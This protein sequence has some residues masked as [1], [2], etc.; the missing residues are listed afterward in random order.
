MFI[1][2]IK[3]LP[4]WLWEARIFWLALSVVIIALVFTLYFCTSESAIRWTGLVLQLLGVGTV[5]WGLR[6][7]R[8]LFGHLSLA[9]KA[10]SWLSRFPLHKRNVIHSSSVIF[11]GG[12]VVSIKGHATHKPS[13]DATM[14]QRLDAL[15]RNID[16]LHDRISGNEDLSNQKFDKTAKSLEKERQDRSAQDQAISRQ[17]EESST[18]G[19]HISAMGAL[20]L[21]IG[22]IFSSGS[23][24]IASWLR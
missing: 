20:W 15:E 23:T 5:A 19:I 24:E 7:A 4:R 16:M 11:D 21:F 18:G 22:V 9:A 3:R 2:D 8:K 10:R 17:L 6:A 13:P 1:S 14:E 12:S